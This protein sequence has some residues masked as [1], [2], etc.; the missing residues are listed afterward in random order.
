VLAAALRGE[1]P[2]AHVPVPAMIDHPG[3]HTLLEVLGA[4]MRA[5]RC[6][7]VQAVSAPW[8]LPV[9]RDEAMAEAIVALSAR[10]PVLVLVGNL[11]AL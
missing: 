3:Y 11:H 10:G 7:E 4:E 6:L 9:G 8:G 1:T 5:S 2:V